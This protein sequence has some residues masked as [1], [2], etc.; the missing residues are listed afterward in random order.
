M[1]IR[2]ITRRLFYN[3]AITVAARLE[4][5]VYSGIALGTNSVALVVILQ[6][7]P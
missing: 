6:E 4:S 1:M 3:L 5:L 7:I 2:K